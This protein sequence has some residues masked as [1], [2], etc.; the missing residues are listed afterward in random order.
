MITRATVEQS[1]LAGNFSAVQIFGATN[2]VFSGRVHSPSWWGIEVIDVVNLTIQDCE[3]AN[4]GNAGIHVLGQ[5][6]Q[7]NV[8]IS[9]CNIFSNAGLGVQSGAGNATILAQGN[10]WGDAAGPA[11]P[12]GDGVDVNVDASNHLAAAVVLNY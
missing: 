2:T 8:T 4:N 12:N 7:T 1:P 11:G 10:W 3:V 9:G 5:S 6:A